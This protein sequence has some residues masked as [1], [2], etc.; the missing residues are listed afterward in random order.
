[1]EGKPLAA[2]TSY[3]RP[4]T[5]HASMVPKQAATTGYRCPAQREEQLRFL[6]I[7][8]A[9]PKRMKTPAETPDNCGGASSPRVI[10]AE[11][12]PLRSSSDFTLQ[13]PSP[14][15]EW[16]PRSKRVHPGDFEATTKSKY[17]AFNKGAP[18]NAV[19]VAR[20]QWTGFSP[21][22]STLGGKHD[23]PNRESG[24]NGVA[25]AKAFAQ[26]PTSVNVGPRSR[27]P[28]RPTPSNTAVPP[29]HGGLIRG[30]RRAGCT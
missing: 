24:A 12:R 23:A 22:A 13:N 27:T 18:N 11:P 25:V 29:L 15:V 21:W 20:P 14:R 26:D 4:P 3:G 6:V 16:A 2:P 9:S 28:R 19:A 10:A 7:T 5:N 30:Q 17:D 8:H 1:M